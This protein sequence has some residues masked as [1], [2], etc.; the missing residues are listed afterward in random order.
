MGVDG[1]KRLASRSTWWHKLPHKSTYAVNAA[2]R[3]GRPAMDHMGI[4][5]H[6][7]ESQI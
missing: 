3:R 1:M 6:G 7:E 2:E 4:D 5:V